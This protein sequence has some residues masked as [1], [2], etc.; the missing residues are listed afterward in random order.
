M[1]RP[2]Q[3]SRGRLAC[4]V[5]V[6]VCVWGLVSLSTLHLA[7]LNRTGGGDGSKHRVALRRG[8]F[9]FIITVIHGRI[10]V[11][12]ELLFRRKINRYD[13]A[14]SFVHETETRDGVRSYYYYIVAVVVA[15]GTRVLHVA[16]VPL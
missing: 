8:G 9:F 4:S 15:L 12:V 2:P 11:F 1:N 3:S 7:R 6:C 5:C 13:L 14:R 16:A 10:Y